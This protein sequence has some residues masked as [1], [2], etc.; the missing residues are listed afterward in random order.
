MHAWNTASLGT[1]CVLVGF[2]PLMTLFTD[3]V[4]DK[5]GLGLK[6]GALFS[7]GLVL[8]QLFL[9]GALCGLD[10]ACSFPVFFLGL[11]PSVWIV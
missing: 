3:G 8:V 11:V 9:G 6:P 5:L 4:S 10:L 2:A 7:S 1:L